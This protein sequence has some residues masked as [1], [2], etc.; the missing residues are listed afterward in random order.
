MTEFLSLLHNP[1]P[2]FLSEFFWADFCSVCLVTVLF[3]LIIHRQATVMLEK[4]I[5]YNRGL[6]KFRTE[7]YTDYEKNFFAQD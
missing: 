5:I 3:Y 2:L 4:N 1:I 6:Y 7:I